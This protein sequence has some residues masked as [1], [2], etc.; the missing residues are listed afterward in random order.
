MNYNFSEYD[1]SLSNL[2]R[3]LFFIITHEHPLHLYEAKKEEKE[4]LKKEM[5]SLSISKKDM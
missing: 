5:D 3:I 2:L 1:R 4:L